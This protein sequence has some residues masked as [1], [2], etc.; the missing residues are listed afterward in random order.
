MVLTGS[1]K[2]ATREGESGLVETGLTGPAAT[3]PQMEKD[4]VNKAEA[5]QMENKILRQSAFGVTAIQGNDKATQFYTG[6]TNY[7]V[8]LHLSG[9]QTKLLPQFE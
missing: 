3:A 8:F 1:T 7:G 5:L 2:Q 9:S 4:L 6:L